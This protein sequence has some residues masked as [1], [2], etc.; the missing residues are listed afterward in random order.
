VEEQIRVAAGLPLRFKQDEIGRRGFAIQFRVNAEDPRNNFLPSFGRI[1]RYYA[2]GGPGIRTDT[3]IY[4]G[5]TI[6]PYYDSMLAKVIVWALNWE[7]A[8]NRGERALRDMGVYG[9]K[10][11]IPY[12][13]EILRNPE[14]RSG[15]FNTGFVE[16]HP[17]LISYSTKRRKDEMAAALAA[18][19]A[20]HAGL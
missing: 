7:D 11:T 9:I 14:F 10:T 15:R 4:T 20:A 6:P 5:Y 18:V 1:S 3:A 19:I 12:Y 17:E 16:A 2:P 8:L 13:L